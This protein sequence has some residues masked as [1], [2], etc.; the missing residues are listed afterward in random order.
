[1]NVCSRL[2]FALCAVT[3]SVGRV[4]VQSPITWQVPQTISSDTDVETQGSLFGAISNG[5]SAVFSVLVNGVSFTQFST[6]TGGSQNSVS[7][8]HFTLSTA[9]TLDGLET[10]GPEGAG[11]SASYSELV[12]AS[13][14]TAGNPATMTLSIN[15]LAIGQLYMVQIWANDSGSVHKSVT[16]T[17]SNSVTLDINTSGGSGRG[18]GQL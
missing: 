4:S 14:Q 1:M 18:R 8:G 2:F 15:D 3:Y 6:A 12:G 16:L 11:V 7:L 9:A 13:S 17:A 10:S 5:G